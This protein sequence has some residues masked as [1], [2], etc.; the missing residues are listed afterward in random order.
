MRKLLG[1]IL[2]SIVIFTSTVFAERNAEEIKEFIQKIE[3]G[4]RVFTAYQISDD[5]EYLLLGGISEAPAPLKLYNKEGDILWVYKPKVDVY[6][7]KLLNNGEV[8]IA[9]WNGKVIFLNIKGEV[10][11]EKNLHYEDCTLRATKNA[12]LGKTFIVI[13][14]RTKTWC[15]NRKG[16]LLW[17]TIDFAVQIFSQNNKY[18]LATSL[19]KNKKTIWLIDPKTKKIYWKSFIPRYQGD[20]I[21]YPDDYPGDVSN[22]GKVLLAAP[23]G[24]E[25]TAPR[26]LLINTKGK[27]I[28][29]K[30]YKKGEEIKILK[31]SS[32]DSKIDFT[33]TKR[34]K[35]LKINNLLIKKNK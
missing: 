18:A 25:Y 20:E 21:S 32:N 4:E 24:S 9:E 29:E 34:K 14:S 13:N 19:E 30:N 17:D 2:I 1:L 15:F 26:I 23:V 8:I 10:K 7:I 3:E 16:N 22:D 35:S 12:R 31:F 5:K 27:L 11:W 33:T 6:E 28:W